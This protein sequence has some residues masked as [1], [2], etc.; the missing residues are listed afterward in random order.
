MTPTTSLCINERKNSV[1]TNDRQRFLKA[2]LLLA[3]Q[4]QKRG[5][6][7]SRKVMRVL[8]GAHG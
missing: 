5:I 3:R 2:A 7:V 1:R 4:N 8:R 6:R